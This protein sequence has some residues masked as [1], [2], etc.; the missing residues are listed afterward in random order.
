MTRRGRKAT[1]RSRRR[2][3]CSAT[4]PPRNRRS[5]RELT[6]PESAAAEG[7]VFDLAGGDLEEIDANAVAPPLPVAPP[8]DRPAPRPREAARPKTDRSDESS[9]LEDEALV[10]EVWTRAAEWGPNLMVVGAWVFVMAML[11]YFLM[12]VLPFGLTFLLLLVAAAGTAVLSYP[13]LI[14]LERPVRMTPE[15]AVRDFYAALSHHLPHYRRMWLLLARPGRTTSSYGSFEG[16]KAYWNEKLRTIKGSRAGTMTPLVFEV[17][18]YRGEK[19]GG[20]SRV[21]RQVHPQGPDPRPEAGRAHRLDPRSGV[22]RARARQ[23]VVPRE[24]HPAP[25]GPELPLRVNPAPS[26]R[27]RGASRIP[28]TIGTT[29]RRFSTFPARSSCM[30]VDGNRGGSAPRRSPA[31]GTEPLDGS[32]SLQVEGI[33]CKRRS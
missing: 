19:S 2:N 28:L 4:S 33:P 13:I 20:K 5:P 15:Q 7:D 22:A 21:E 17:E 18:D 25:A 12:G 1:R 27:I 16:F 9:A 11:I 6:A 23:D 8:R 30:L 26:S 29:G 10:D 3:S 24:R 31:F 32:W 14:T